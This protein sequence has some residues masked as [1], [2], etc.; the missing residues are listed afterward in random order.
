MKTNIRALCR[1]EPNQTPLQNAF[2]SSGISHTLALD[3]QRDAMYRF[4]PTLIFIIAGLLSVSL[5]S[6]GDR[7]RAFRSCI[8]KCSFSGGCQPHNLAPVLRV[9]RWTCEDECTYHCMHEFTTKA[10]DSGGRVHQYFGKWPF[11]RWHGM[12]EPASVAF[13]FLNMWFHVQ[14]ALRLRV[15]VPGSHPMKVFYLGW[16]FTSIN[17]WIWSAVFHTRGMFCLILP[18]L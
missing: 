6:S 2:G 7:S 3:A 10:L 12:Q 4:L 5:A 8:T 18:A 11:W 16:A 9:L 15:A 14:G 1:I 17:T 13:S